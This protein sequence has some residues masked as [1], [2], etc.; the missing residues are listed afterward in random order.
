M[1]YLVESFCSIQG[2]GKFIGRPSI[3]F[4]F[5]GCN[6]SCNGFKTEYKIDNQ[7][8]FGCDSF[9]AVDTKFKKNWQE[10]NTI[11][12]LI[13]ELENYK[14]EFNNI[15]EIVITGGEP[16]IYANDSIFLEFIKYLN[17]N[18]YQITIET[19]GS[20]E[21]KKE[22]HEIYQNT[23]FAMSIKLA[24]SNEE[25]KKR[26]NLR[27]IESLIRINKNSFFKFTLSKNDIQNGILDEIVILKT[28]FSD[29]QIYCMPTASNKEELELNSISVIDFCI[30]NGFNYS[31]RLHI[32]VWNNKRGT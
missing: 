19:N 15:N 22:L 4:R 32:R 5:G 20:K 13:Q 8:F 27:A 2:E 25:F 23:I 14:K 17:K 11:N 24:N 9:Y 12:Q 31:D 18:N 29:T 26:I 3:F 28:H 21:I 7:T 16:L 30:K 1:V 6:M 10:I